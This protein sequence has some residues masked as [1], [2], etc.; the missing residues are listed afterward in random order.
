[1]IVSNFVLNSTETNVQVT[2]WPLAPAPM[3]VNST[4]TS[5]AVTV[6]LADMT[7]YEPITY[8]AIKVKKTL[9]WWLESE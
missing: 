7:I 1:M 5:I 8:V 9:L 3:I 4:N 2:P 6:L